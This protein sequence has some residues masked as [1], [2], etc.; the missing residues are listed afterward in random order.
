MF[1]LATDQRLQSKGFSIFLE[2]PGHL[3]CFYYFRGIRN[4]KMKHIS[5]VAAVIIHDHKILCVRRGPA[6]YAYIS[7]KW[8]FPGGKI[9]ENETKIEALSREIREELH[10]TISVD[11]FLMTVQH[12]YPDFHLTMDTFLCSC[13][14][15]TLT[16]TEHTDF[17]WLDLNELRTLDWAA[18]DVPIVE[19]LL[20]A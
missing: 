8:E 14:D 11:A 20:V 16:L 3:D 12:Q 13:A 17:K 6:K 9:E 2:I 19:K 18:A 4:L 5:V 10:M 15:D 1:K 7:D